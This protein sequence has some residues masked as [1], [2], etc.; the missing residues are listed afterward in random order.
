MIHDIRGIKGIPGVIDEHITFKDT[1]LNKLLNFANFIN[2]P[3]MPEV[4]GIVIV[5]EVI[6]IKWPELLRSLIRL[7]GFTGASQVQGH[8]FFDRP[9]VKSFS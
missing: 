6:G 8:L 3:I 9:L 2:V 7:V 1:F 5:V 4:K